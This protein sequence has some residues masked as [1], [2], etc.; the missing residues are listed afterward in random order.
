MLH[1]LLLGF[2]TL[3]ALAFPFA[4]VRQPEVRYD[5]SASDTAAAIPLLPYQPLRERAPTVVERETAGWTS[6]GHAR[7]PERDPIG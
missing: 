7:V 5:W 6:V 4:P 2:A 3:T 1:R